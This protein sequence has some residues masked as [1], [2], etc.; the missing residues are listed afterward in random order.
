MEGL[1]RRLSSDGSEAENALRVIAFFDKLVEAKGGIDELA[2]S[3]ARLMGAPAGFGMEF[4]TGAVAFDEFGRAVS[5]RPTSTAIVKNIDVDST[6][7]GTVWVD[8]PPDNHALGELVA[9]RMALSAGVILNRSGSEI[10]AS[11]STALTQIM[12]EAATQNDRLAAART[13]GFRADWTVRILLIRNPKTITEAARELSRWAERCGVKVTA[14]LLDNEK[15]MALVHDSGSDLSSQDCG[16]LG[17]VAFG[18][19]ASIPDILHSLATARQALQLTSRTLGPL[20]IDYERLG[21]LAH[22]SALTPD[23]AATT[24]MVQKLQFL[25]Q[26][27]LGRTELLAVDA[28]CRHRSLRLASAEM[29]LHHSSL[30][31]RLKN[32]QRKLGIDLAE[33]EVLFQLSLSLQLYRVAA[34]G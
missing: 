29:N 2:R 33:P 7:V 6:R 11:S 15:I 17:L 12:S 21:P 14:P 27:D 8:V 25:A 26:S 9:E 13:L 18:A 4:D 24:V 30:S 1:L 19:R 16:N 20:V 5:P 32:A 34:A 22:I 3:S 23:Q 31:N 28:F 10:G